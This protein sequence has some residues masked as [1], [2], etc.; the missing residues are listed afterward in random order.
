MMLKSEFSFSPESRPTADGAENDEIDQAK[1]EE[2]AESLAC[3][4]ES[5]ALEHTTGLIRDTPELAPVIAEFVKHEK[6]R[7]RIGGAAIVEELA[8]EAPR[9]AARFIPH[10]LPLLTHE[11]P[12]V[13]GDT[14]SLLIMIGGDEYLPH[15]RPLLE[16]PNRQVR[17]I[18]QEIIEEQEEK[19]A[20]S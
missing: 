6:M 17:E 8:V 7:V 9:A 4:L 18:I 13:R 11:N 19:S 3:Y 1:I 16:D 10:L 15:I 2:Y 5:G 12:V 14:A 20:S